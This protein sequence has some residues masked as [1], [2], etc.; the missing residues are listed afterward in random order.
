[1]DADLDYMRAAIKCY[2]KDGF[3]V[4]REQFS[5]VNHRTTISRYRKCVQEGHR[6]SSKI[7]HEKTREKLVKRILAE[8]RATGTKIG[9]R[10][11]KELFHE[12][13]VD[14]AMTLSNKVCSDALKRARTCSKL[15]KA[16]TIEQMDEFNNLIDAP[17]AVENGPTYKDWIDFDVQWPKLLLL[18]DSLTQVSSRTNLFTCNFLPN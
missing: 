9:I 8:E 13:K 2:D 3:K 5:K 12:V 7:A 4:C 11:V 6:S 1:M 14:R 18:G 16:L 10:R 17:M 15:C